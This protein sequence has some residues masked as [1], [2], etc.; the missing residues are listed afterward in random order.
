MSL[1]HL[2]RHL[3]LLLKAQFSQGGTDF[4]GTALGLGKFSRPTT[5]PP[6]PHILLPPAPRNDDAAACACVNAAQRRL[7]YHLLAYERLL[8]QNNLHHVARQAWTARFRAH[9]IL[10]VPC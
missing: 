5:L 6:T 9:V 1:T 7:K 4:F 10:R 2:E 8:P 3:S